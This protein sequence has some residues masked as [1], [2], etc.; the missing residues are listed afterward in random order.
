MSKD[1]SNPIITAGNTPDIRIRI[2]ENG[3]A[4]N[5]T[6]LLEISQSRGKG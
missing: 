5:R 6:G 4:T 1:K 2:F 3:D